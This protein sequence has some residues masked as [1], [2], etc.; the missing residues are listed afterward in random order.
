MKARRGTR[1]FLLCFFIFGLLRGSI[2]LLAQNAPTSPV[3]AQ[4]QILEPDLEPD[5]LSLITITVNGQSMGDR[6]VGIFG[7]QPILPIALMRELLDPFLSPEVYDTI[8]NVVFVKLDWVSESDA[9]VVGLGWN[10]DMAHIVLNLSVPAKYS[11]YL[12][13]DVN[14]SYAA[15]IKP[16][17]KPV[18]FSGHIDFR[19]NVEMK[20]SSVKIDTPADL[21]AESSFNLLGWV[22]EV[23][24][25]VKLES[26][27]V[28]A[29]L[30]DARIIHDFMGIKGRMALGKVSSPGLAYQSQPELYGLTLKKEEILQYRVKPGFL[31]L[32]TEF[33]VETPSTVRLIIN[34]MIYRTITLDPGNYRILDLPFSNGVN[35]FVIEIEDEAGRKRRIQA[36]VPRE[37]NLLVETTSDYAFSA[38]MGRVEY[39]QPFV[40]GY[41]RY[42]FSPRFTAGLTAQAD[43]R[44]ALAGMNF[45]LATGWGGFTGA[46]A[47]V[48]AW[49]G[50]VRPLTFAASLQYR[51]SLPGKEYFPTIGVSGEYKSAGFVAPMPSA[52]LGTSD[53]DMRFGLQL[54]GKLS[55]L[56]SYSLSGTY[57]K[58]GGVAPSSSINASASINRS[59]GQGN[60]LSVVG[61]MGKTAGENPSFTLSLMLFILPQSKAGRSWSFIQSGDSS[62]TVSYLDK[63]DILGGL[64]LNLS[65][66]N[67]MI[68]SSEGSAAGASL[69]KSLDWGDLSLSGR[70]N[71]GNP[72]SG[73]Y[74]S[75]SAS[76]STTLAFAGR[77]AAITRQID[78]SFAILAPAKDLEGQKIYF[79]IDGGGSVQ[80]DAGKPV[81][82]PIS[83]YKPVAA[84][85]ELP[86]APPDIVPSVQAALLVPSLRSAIVYST[87]SLKR[88]RVS[89][90]L[91]SADGKPYDY[92]AGDLVDLSGTN[93]TSTFT[94]LDGSFELYDLAPGKYTIYWPE[95]VGTSE[96]EVTDTETGVVELGIVVPRGTNSSGN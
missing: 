12:D 67:L 83:S 72:I 26:D 56:S 19:A 79:K 17:L 94:D 76:A 4:P 50:R 47:L 81:I 18:P 88:Y 1:V 35:D 90:K 29:E 32:F 22:A 25:R 78:D 38:G 68:G 92:I 5:L 96:I 7:D 11:P 55:R 58:T 8:F 34:E 23:S 85:I 6:E 30:A 36:T 27:K 60:S 49:D 10:W 15:N 48:G 28:S 62:N 41:F 87:G 13:I 73:T 89:G 61:T 71:Y 84:H 45:V 52:T 69:R 33:T 66:T 59:L 16:I 46:G 43:L 54:G 44:S 53:E 40:S 21:V 80:S 3:D 77:Y 91:E 2:P 70:I 14:P 86:E 57:S 64:D 20:I 37:M 63:L 82:V 65:A 75:L 39:D 42:G 93:L 24:S 9:Q 51:L 95:S 31:E 74:G